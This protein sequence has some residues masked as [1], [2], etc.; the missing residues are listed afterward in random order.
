MMIRGRHRGLLHRLDRAIVLP[1]DKSD[2]L[3]R[4]DEDER[5]AWRRSWPELKRLKVTYTT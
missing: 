2:A 5:L 3:G 1:T 4:E